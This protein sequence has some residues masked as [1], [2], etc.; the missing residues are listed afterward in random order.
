MPTKPLQVLRAFTEQRSEVEAAGAAG[1]A[2]AVLAVDADDDRGTT[3]GLGDAR[4][5]D[6]DD[7]RRPPLSA[8]HVAVARP[9][10]ADLLLGGSA[11]AE[12]GLAASQ[13]APLEF[14]DEACGLV[15]GA[16]TQEREGKVGAG[17]ASSS[18][19]TRR[20]PEGDRRAVERRGIHAGGA[21][22]RPEPRAART[23]EGREPGAHERAVLAGERHAVGDRGEGDELGDAVTERRCAL[24]GLLEQRM[25]E[26][27]GNASATRR[28]RS[29]DDVVA[30]D[31]R[32]QDGRGRQFAALPRE[33]V[34]GDQHVDARCPQLRDLLHRRDPAVDGDHER[35]PRRPIRSRLVAVSP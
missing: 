8:E 14:L 4:R 7:P 5:D 28:R 9:E 17:D 13:V 29:L 26:M 23:G 34:V 18:V 2:G 33:V 16:R 11:H 20:E 3:R 24:A 6:A 32:M 35:R 22:E 21:Q 19:Q 12:L 10:L 15:V 25:C 1:G 31:R 27:A 30:A